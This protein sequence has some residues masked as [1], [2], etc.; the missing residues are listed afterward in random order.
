MWLTSDQA[1]RGGG[2]RPRH[3]A[4][5]LLTEPDTVSERGQPEADASHLLALVLT[6]QS[7]ATPAGR[8]PGSCL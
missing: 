4:R 8:R 1:R 2:P 6:R 7:A 5:I 3:R